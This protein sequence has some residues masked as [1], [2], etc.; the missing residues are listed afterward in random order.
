[1]WS[2]LVLETIIFG[3]GLHNFLTITYISGRRY[4]FRSATLKKDTIIVFLCEG[5]EKGLWSLHHWLLPPLI[6]PISALVLNHNSQQTNERFRVSN[7]FSFRRTWSIFRPI[8]W[9]WSGCFVKDGRFDR[10][11]L[12]VA[13]FSAREHCGGNW[14][15]GH[16]E[17]H[18]NLKDENSDWNKKECFKY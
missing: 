4:C 11:V 13:N 17:R 10:I 5:G 15:G 8:V 9:K 12:F 7:I 1:M 3:V 6:D 18:H 14:H 16:G 2:V